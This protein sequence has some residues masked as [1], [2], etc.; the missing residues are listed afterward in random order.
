MCTEK[1]IV[2]IYFKCYIA[3]K[4]NLSEIFVFYY[5]SDVVF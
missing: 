4:C 5:F 3:L 2:N 1:H